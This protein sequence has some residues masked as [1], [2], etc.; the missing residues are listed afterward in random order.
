[1]VMDDLY[2][3]NN[4]IRWVDQLSDQNY[5]AIDDFISDEELDSFR[6]WFS[7]QLENEEF[8]KAGI[9]TMDQY[10]VRGEI[11]GDY[12]KWLSPE[13]DLP[14]V[15]YFER[16]ELIIQNLNRLCFLSLSGYE[17]H[18]AHYPKG[19]FYKRH[20]DQ[21]QQRSNRLISVIL[22]LNKGW[23]EGD[24]GELKVFLDGNREETIRPLAKRLVLMRSDLV[25]HEVLETHR[26]RYSITGWLLYK[27]VGLSFL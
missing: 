17:F 24:G 19:T 22:Y 8:S 5:L 26:D 12:I 27:P 10:Q 9:G 13:K 4:M 15:P 20:L 18:F 14:I 16:I 3:E 25:E 2:H 23:E 21:F 1:M 11:R 7:I 6:S